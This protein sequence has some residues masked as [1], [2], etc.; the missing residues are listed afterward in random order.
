MGFLR[1]F[2]ATSVVVRHSG[3]SFLGSSLLD[4]DTA[5]LVFFCISGFLITY[6]LEKRYANDLLAF[7]LGRALRI[8]PP[9]LVILAVTAACGYF[10]LVDLGYIFGEFGSPYHNLMEH[11]NEASIVSRAVIVGAN[12]FTL[13]QDALRGVF[14]DTSTGNFVGHHNYASIGGLSFTLI[15][16]AWTLGVEMMFYLLAPFIVRRLPTLWM[17]LIGCVAI[18]A[19]W[20][21]SSDVPAA[22]YFLSH[23][24]LLF[25]NELGKIG[26]LVFFLAGASLCHVYM[27][28]KA[29]SFVLAAVAV[30]LIGTMGRMQGEPRD[31]WLVCLTLLIPVA[32]GASTKWLRDDFLG[33]LSYPVY[34]THVLVLQASVG[35]VA[36]LGAGYSRAL[37]PMIFGGTLLVSTLLVIALE[38]PI[39]KLRHA[40]RRSGTAAGQESLG[41]A[42]LR[43]AGE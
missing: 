11:W 8:Y 42:V 32:F 21:R 13:G 36:L 12:I 22:L 23:F 41:S 2:L 43:R 7:Y 10:N 16:Q 38:R 35:I 19:A 31:V 27:R 37:A 29:E 34:I 18:A 40:L 26:F 9:Y 5:V 1:L 28:P 15:G 6:A 14:F 3:Q 4:A 17:A 20:P 33:D 30:A 39:K 25:P 24:T